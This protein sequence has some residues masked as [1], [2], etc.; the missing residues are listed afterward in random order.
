MNQILSFR[1][2]NLI[3][4]GFGAAEK[5]GPEAKALGAKS[6]LLVTDKGVADSGIADT[7]KNILVKEGIGVEVFSQVKPEPDL[8]CQ[9]AC[10][11]AARQGKYDL[12]VGLGGGSAMDVA[13]VT[14][15]MLTNPGKVTDYVGADLIK[16]PGIPTVLLP[17][18]A[19]T[20]AEVTPNAVLSD[21]AA[22]GKKVLISPYILP[23]IAI[24]DPYL[25]VSMPP[26]VTSA[27]GMDA[28]AHAVES[29]THFT[30]A[31][32]I[33]DVFA[34]EAMVMISRSIRT[35]VAK[36]ENLEARY[37]MAIGSLF[38]GIALA[39][40]GVNGVHALS[41]PL[42]VE[43]HVPHGV[44]NG[45]LLPYVMEFNAIGNIPKFAEI[46]RCLGEDVEGLPLVEQA[47]AAAEAVKAIL[48]DMKMAHS[49]TDL[50]ISV[51]AIPAMAKA[52]ASNTRLL[53][54]NPRAMTAADV[55]G[56]YRNCL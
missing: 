56:I 34:K 22:K 37:D 18:T 55:E 26:S 15:I 4:A 21:P 41:Y 20:G 10:I 25:H 50:K 38:A 24:I 7:I 49:L 8:E 51:D 31:T 17:T 23:R 5:L 45:L 46:A 39:N 36:G 44:A 52:A 2:P 11:A 28:L 13:A 32:V 42:G 6:A 48:K 29:F 40:A 14:A 19:G 12:I 27:S 3:L 33:T 16:K 1:S 43:Y 54:V 47:Y 9:D 35:A 53:S 30:K